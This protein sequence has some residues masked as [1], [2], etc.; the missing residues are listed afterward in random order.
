MTTK[1]QSSCTPDLGGAEAGVVVIRDHVGISQRTDAV[2][3]GLIVILQEHCAGVQVC[4]SIQ[5]QIEEYLNDSDDEMVWVKRVKYLLCLPL[6]LYLKNEPPASPDKAFAFTG[7][8]RRWTR[9]RLN[10]YNNKN[11][12]LWYSWFQAKRCS[13]I[14]SDKF[15]SQCYEEH[16]ASLT[17]DDPGDEFAIDA[18]FS[19]PAFFETLEKLRT[20]IDRVLEVEKDPTIY[21]PSTSASFEL[22]RNEGGQFSCLRYHI[23][24]SS[25]T[26]EGYEEDPGLYLPYNMTYFTSDL[27]SMWDCSLVLGSSSRVVEVRQPCGWEDWKELAVKHLKLDYDTSPLGAKIQGIIEPL[28]VRVISKGESLPYYCHIRLQKALHGVMRKM[29]CFR[30]LGRPV[31]PTDLLDIQGPADWEWFSIDYSAATDGLSWKFSSRIL[32]FLLKNLPEWERNAAL[33]V[34]G[35]HRLSYPVGKGD[36]IEKGIQRNGQL[37]GSILSFPILCLANLA[38]YL[39]TMSPLQVGWNTERRLAGVL[40]NGDDMVYAAP[41]I[42]EGVD[43]WK[44]HIKVSG[45]LGL[46]MSVGKAYHHR[47][48]ANVNS[49]SFDCYAGCT[50]IDYLNLGLL[51]NSEVQKKRGDDEEGSSLTR[52]LNTL[53]DGCRNHKSQFRILSKFLELHK[54]LVLKESTC[55][56]LDPR[57]RERSFVRNLFLPCAFGGM[58]VNPP[59]GWRFKIKKFD[60]V[61][62]RNL[63]PGVELSPLPLPGFPVREVP[64]DG[65]PWFKT[66]A[67]GL[68]CIVLRD[69]RKLP[70]KFSLVQPLFLW[71]PNRRVFSKCSRL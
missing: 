52:G 15:I 42:H 66:R 47:R 7:L 26:R 41:P 12:H 38:T 68:S 30:L 9:N 28:K 60:R 61:V 6:A 31:S 48:Y 14:C 46:K 13:L 1:K 43:M 2:V 23:L 16:Y 5:K 24:G 8:A 64:K 51:F 18:A 37:M 17:K 63:L 27:H 57:G 20:A 4:F 21:S 71:A 3:R 35:P 55:Q 62:A 22:T 67:D 19:N 39:I 50:Q 44:R 36:Y 53:L 56:Y 58:G 34:L 45:D 25:Y 70:R 65:A 69:F 54:E 11:T 29:N 49:T 10:V 32:R 59:M 40:V 33:R